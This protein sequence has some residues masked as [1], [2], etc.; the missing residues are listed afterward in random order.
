MAGSVPRL[1]PNEVFVT[2]AEDGTVQTW[3]VGKDGWCRKIYSERG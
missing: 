1:E 2:S 3:R